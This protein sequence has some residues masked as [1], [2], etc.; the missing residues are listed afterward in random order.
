[1]FL[2]K[3]FGNNGRLGNQ[4]FQYLLL[5]SLSKEYSCQFY[6]PKIESFERYFYLQNLSYVNIELF[7]GV[8]NEEFIDSN[9]FSFQKFPIQNNNY[10]FNGYFQNIQYFISDIDNILSNELILNQESINLSK[11]YLKSIGVNPDNS[12]A[13]HVRRTDYV[14]HSDTYYQLYL[15]NYY[16]DAMKYIWC[17]NKNIK[18]IIFS[19]DKSSVQ[20]EFSSTKYNCIFSNN[21]EEIDFLSM[22]LC[23]YKIIA[24]STFSLCAALLNRNWDKSTVVYPK[25]WLKKN[26]LNPLGAYKPKKW[27]SI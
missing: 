13:I 11:K 5:Y 19:D 10:N 15:S 6:L 14:Y 24:N 7:D 16:N 9:P 20:N 23:K 8:V 3:N 2:M 17:L 18:F 4:I 26:H 22:N 12:C 27:I 21:T 25:R 1:M